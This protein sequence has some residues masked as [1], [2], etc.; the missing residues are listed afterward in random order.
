MPNRI[1]ISAG[2]LSG[3]EQAALV[4]AALK[5]LVPNVELRG[6]GGTNLRRAGVD[7]VVDSETSASVMGVFEI[8]GSLSKIRQALSKLE[9]LLDSWRPELL[10]LVDYPDFNLRL[11]RAAKKRGIPV[12]YF[13]PPK[14][15]AWRQGR[16]K[17]LKELCDQIALIFPFE[18]RFYHSHGVTQVTYV[19]HPLSAT[20]SDAP[21]PTQERSELM[22]S[23]GLNPHLPTVALFPGSRR[24]EI[25]RHLPPLLQ[26]FSELK[27]THPDVQAIVSRAGT[28]REEQVTRYCESERNIKVTSLDAVTILKLSDTAIMKSGTSNLQAALSGVPF[29]MYY[30]LPVWANIFLRPIVKIREYSPVNIVKSKTVK[31]IVTVVPP[32]KLLAKE[33]ENLLFD[34][35]LRDE[36]RC[37]LRVVADLLHPPPSNEFTEHTSPAARVALL[38]CNT[39]RPGAT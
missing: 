4:A 34:G 29:T 14:V 35:T 33:M 32:I 5:A 26:A 7:T 12:L 21:L 38:A 27:R 39:I 3:D 20:I 2:E 23:I 10:I 11:A 24:F 36:I 16:I 8:I 28:I 37:R 30:H 17:V 9:E 19:G 18:E 13:I 31:E 22:S 1:F 25:D 6:M 15:W